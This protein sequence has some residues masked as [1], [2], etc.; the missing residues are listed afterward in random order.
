MTTTGKLLDLAKKMA[1][2][3][4]VKAIE[5]DVPMVIA[6]CDKHGNPVLFN[7]MEDSLLASIDIATNKAYTAAALKGSTDQ[8]ADVAK[9]AGSLFGLAS[10][11]KGRM[12]VFG[13]GFPIIMDGEIIGGIGVSG[14][15]VEEDMTVAKAGLAIL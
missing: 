10:C 6:I 15:S 2:A 1:D 5:I 7:R 9:E 14:G 3:A 12:V 13:G 8:F 4:A 11:D